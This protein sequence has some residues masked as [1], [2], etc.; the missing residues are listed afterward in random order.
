MAHH[1][2][3]SIS[4]HL[5]GSE[6]KGTYVEIFA[7]PNRDPFHEKIWINKPKISDGYIDVPNEIGLGVKLDWD[8][9]KKYS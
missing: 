2:E 9:V 1:E 5:L 8:L 4:R 7:D 6:V 3:A